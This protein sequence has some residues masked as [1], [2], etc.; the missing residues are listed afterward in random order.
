MCVCVSLAAN[1]HETASNLHVRLG[2]QHCPWEA[3]ISWRRS[4][5][6]VGFTQGT[7]CWRSALLHPEAF[8][9]SSAISGGVSL[10]LPH[11]GL[12]EAAVH[13]S[14]QRAARPSLAPVMMVRRVSVKDPFKDAWA[15]AAF[16]CLWLYPVSGRT[17]H[18]GDDGWL[19]LSEMLESNAVIFLFSCT[20]IS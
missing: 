14:R 9:S 5:S 1:P 4:G 8:L 6:C 13:S 3:Q 7:L 12:E 18:L 17:V 2:A 11:A 20:P 16:Q 15:A 19:F 10:L